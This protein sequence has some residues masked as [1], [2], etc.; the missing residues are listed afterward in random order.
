M[1]ELLALSIAL[2][3]LVGSAHAADLGVI[4]QDA[5]AGYI[6]S[7]WTGV[8]AVSSPVW[9]LG[10]MTFRSASAASAALPFLETA[11]GASPASRSVPTTRWATL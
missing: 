11:A 2:S 3:L 1:N 10:R 8:Y 7:D 9:A 6:S 4:A 5:T